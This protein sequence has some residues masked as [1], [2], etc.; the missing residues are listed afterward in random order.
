VRHHRLAQAE[1]GAGERRVDHGAADAVVHRAAVAGAHV[2]Q[3]IFFAGEVAHRCQPLA[4]AQSQRAP[5]R[6]IALSGE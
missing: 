4:L 2:L 3:V 5:K 1:V 6:A